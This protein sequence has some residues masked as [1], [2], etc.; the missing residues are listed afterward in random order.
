MKNKYTG[1]LMREI[2]QK[3]QVEMSYILGKVKRTARKIK[4]EGDQ[5]EAV[6]T[7]VYNYLG[8]QN[9]SKAVEDYIGNYVKQKEERE[10]MFQSLQSKTDTYQGV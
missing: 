1:H 4:N 5:L 3:N 7:S 6:K 10:R 8:I 2:Q 9:P